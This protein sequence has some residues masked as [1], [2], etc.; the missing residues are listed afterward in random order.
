MK[1]IISLMLTAALL[2]TTAGCSLIPFPSAETTEP[3]TQETTLET[4]VQTT[5][6]EYTD[7]SVTYHAPMSAV[8]L[9]VITESSTADDGTILFTYEYQNMTLSLQDAAIADAILVDFL[10]R[11]DT[12]DG[13]AT[14]MQQS[15]VS[16]YTGQED[17][18]PYSFRMLYQPMRFDEMVLSLYGLESIFGGYTHGNFANLSVNYDLLTGKVLGIRDILVADYSAESLIEYIIQGLAEYEKEDMLFPDYKELI[19]DMFFTNHPVENWYFAQD[20]L[21]FFF[22]PYEI[23]PYSSGTLVSKVPYESLS[24]LLKDSYFPAESV[25]FSGAPIC[26]KFSTMDA[27]N[28]SRFAELIL[29]VDG[30]QVLLYAD[31]TLLNV[32][33]ET[34]TWS[35]NGTEFTPEATV[36]AATAISKGDAVMIQCQDFSQLR[37]TYESQGQVYQMPVLAQ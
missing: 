13:S 23:A 37:L 12:S 29:D 17:W 2:L 28:I 3:S 31:G 20:G 16:D 33:V 4:T 7:P 15:A 6:T 26:E 36:F 9:P 32:R 19:S 10:N 30:E 8:S 22:S 18:W 25:S 14:A 21:C 27:A 35:E 11:Q 5:A 1:K 34:G 24:G